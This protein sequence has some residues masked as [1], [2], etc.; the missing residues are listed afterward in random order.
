MMMA[1]DS[2]PTPPP[3]LSEELIA[4]LRAALISF[5]GNPVETT[6]LRDTLCAIAREARQKQIRAEHVLIA[7]KEVWGELPQVRFAHDP[8]EQTRAL[9][10]L[11]TLCIREYYAE[12]SR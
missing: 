5:A 11:V 2:N 12:D 8:R 7:L 4:R 1:H 6:E 3:R 10:Q 9:Q